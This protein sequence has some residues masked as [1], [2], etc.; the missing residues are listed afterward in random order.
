MNQFK[1]GY[2]IRYLCLN[3]LSNKCGEKV[4]VFPNVYILNPQNLS[5]GTNI[6]IHENSYI[7][8]H[9][10]LDIGSNVAIAHNVSI[11]TFDHYIDNIN[12]PIK[13]SG[14]NAKPVII[15][16]DVW[17]GAGARVLKGVVINSHCVIASGAVLTKTTEPY[18]IYS[19]VPAKL[20]RLRR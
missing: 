9:G 8:A 18:G 1:V 16:D 12:V 17:I 10:G 14:S 19:G 5:I 2:I 11:L 15:C 13:D 6:S 4:I 20:I 7:D 3:K